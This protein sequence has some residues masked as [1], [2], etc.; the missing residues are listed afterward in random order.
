[1]RTYEQP[2]KMYIGPGN[3]GNLIRSLMKKRFWFVE[4]SNAKDANFAWTQIKVEAVF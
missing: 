4:C 3:N 2:V 1:M